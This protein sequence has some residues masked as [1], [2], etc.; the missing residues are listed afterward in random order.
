VATQQI[1]G[2]SI[3]DYDG[4]AP[5]VAFKLGSSVDWRGS[6][7][8]VS[9]DRGYV[10]V[11][12]AVMELL[13]AAGKAYSARSAERCAATS[14]RNRCDLPGGHD[15]DHLVV[16]VVSTLSWANQDDRIARGARAGTTEA[17]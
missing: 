5:P 1:D 7:V 17:A 3:D 10:F 15:G 11:P 4:Q 6:D 16:G 12:V 2:W 9:G 13:I 14:G 8:E